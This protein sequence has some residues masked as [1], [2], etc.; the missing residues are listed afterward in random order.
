MRLEFGFVIII[1]CLLFTGC[2]IS[3]EEYDRLVEEEYK[4]KAEL[5]RKERIDI[6]MKEKLYR[7]ELLADSI[8]KYRQLNPLRENQYRPNIPAR[9]DFIQT[10]ST[11]V[12]S[13]QSV[14]P[15]LDPSSD[16]R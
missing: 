8:I 5:L 9:P 16:N 4:R 3:E 15:I 10:D 6:C 12:N 2:D 13:K 7:A 1:S 11:A 14:K